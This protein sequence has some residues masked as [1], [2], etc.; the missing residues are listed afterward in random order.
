MG[1][2]GVEPVDVKGVVVVEDGTKGGRSLKGRGRGWVSVNVVV[3]VVVVNVNDGGVD[4][5][6]RF[7][8]LS[9]DANLTSESSSCFRLPFEGFF[10]KWYRDF[11][12]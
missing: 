3:V 10:A 1:E 5:W 7:F 6:Q 4:R 11:E 2:S 12:L 8:H 9:L